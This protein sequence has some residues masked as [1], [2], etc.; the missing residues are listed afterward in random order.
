MGFT[1]LKKTIMDKAEAEA[2][3]ILKS[4]HKEAEDSKRKIEVEMDERLEKVNNELKSSI[5]MMENRELAAANLE[6]KK[7]LLITKK[8]MIEKV[9]S[10]VNKDLGKKLTKQERKAIISKLMEKA[11]NEIQIG[12]VY[13]NKIDKELCGFPKCVEKDILGGIIAEDKSGKVLVDYSFETILQ[14]IKEKNIAKVTDIL[15]K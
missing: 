8:E 5:S 1:Q 10:E 9:F 4:A 2:D 14:D 13:C 3:S 11:S 12:K 15:F 7:R 6:S